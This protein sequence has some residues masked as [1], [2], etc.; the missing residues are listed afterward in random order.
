MPLVVSL[1][2]R[3]DVTRVAAEE[4]DA[5]LER[6]ATLIGLPAADR[7][8]HWWW[9]RAQRPFFAIA[10]DLDRGLFQATLALLAGGEREVL[11]AITDTSAPPWPTFRGAAAALVA[12]VEDAPPAEFFVTPRSGGWVAF[13]THHNCLLLAGTRS[14]A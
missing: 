12:A 1:G 13:D 7:T 4:S 6:I 10:Y 14:A 8:R 2:S 5:L 3:A 9:I 11:L